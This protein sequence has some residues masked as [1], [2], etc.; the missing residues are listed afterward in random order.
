[1]I[2]SAKQWGDTWTGRT[3]VL[4]CDNDSVVDCTVYKKPRDPSLLSLLREFLHV[5]VTKKF[6]PVVRKIGTKQNALADHISR[7]FDPEAAK[8]VFAKSGLSDMVL[9]KPRA[10]Y[11]SLTAPW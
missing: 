7:R 10:D 5:V 4:Y 8:Q 9:V 2:V 11:F 6:F 3:I 1:M